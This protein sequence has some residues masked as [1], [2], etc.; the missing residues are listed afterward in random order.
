MVAEV[1]SRPTEEYDRAGKFSL[2]QG[3]PT[4]EEYMLIATREVR[5]DVR[6][7]TD[8]GAWETRVHGPG[9]E[10]VLTSVG[11]TFPMSRLYRGTSLDRVS[12]G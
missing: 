11:L 9:S 4:L 1:L 8:D 5:V 2:Y 7:R 3:C 6:A 12:R 10:V